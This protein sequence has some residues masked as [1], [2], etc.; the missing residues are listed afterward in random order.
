MV[1]LGLNVDTVKNQLLAEMDNLRDDAVVIVLAATNQGEALDQALLR[2]GRFDRC[3]ACSSFPSMMLRCGIGCKSHNGV[4][5]LTRITL[6]HGLV[7]LSTYFSLLSQRKVTVQYPDITER[8]DIL[9]VCP[10]LFLNGS[11]W[12]TALCLLP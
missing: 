8:M 12:S 1:F 4:F 7:V 10:P 5:F 9:E 11:T 2:A 6:Y 3:V